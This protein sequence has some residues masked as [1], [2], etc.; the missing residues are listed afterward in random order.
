MLIQNED[1]SWQFPSSYLC[2]VHCNLNCIYNDAHAY[3][4][5]T[6]EH[7]TQFIELLEE[8]SFYVSPMLVCSA[9]AITWQLGPEFDEVA[10]QV[11]ALTHARGINTRTGQNFYDAIFPFR[12]R[13]KDETKP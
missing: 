4:G 2:L 6:D 10:A 8:M 5:F 3:I 12:L 9:T 13:N 7:K 11:R 1:G